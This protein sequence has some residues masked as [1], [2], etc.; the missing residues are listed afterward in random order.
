LIAVAMLALALV[1][2]TGDSSKLT[3]EEI[4][5]ALKSRL[6][7]DGR[8]DSSMIVVSVEQGRATLS[9]L[10]KT[11]E[12][13]NL[14]DVIVSSTVGVRAVMNNI[15]VT[16]VVTKDGAIK[17]GVEGAF[18][19]VPALQGSKLTVSVNK[20]VV[21]LEGAVEKPLGRQV[22]QRAAESVPGVVAVVN[23]LKVAGVPRP[24]REI[25]KD[26]VM[27]LQWS[28]LVRLDAFEY[29]VQNGIVKLKGTVDHLAHRFALEKDLEKIQ[30]VV[31]VDVSEVTVKRSA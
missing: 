23:M 6:A 24:D 4:A 17:R 27:Y 19:S 14:A 31:G 8:I 10:V 29:T 28:P 25:E 2:F 12:E 26:V 13:K 5:S 11:L 20:G 22:A 3:D 1:G 9:G 7:M 15:V 16:P 18:R 21:K 30:G